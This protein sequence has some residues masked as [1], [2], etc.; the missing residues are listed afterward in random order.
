MQV[1]QQA[2]LEGQNAT[3]DAKAARRAELEN[4]GRDHRDLFVSFF[5]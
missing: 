5:Y 1:R 2:R 3:R 4:T